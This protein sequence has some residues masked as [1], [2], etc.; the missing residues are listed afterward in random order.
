LKRNDFGYDPAGNLY[1]ALNIRSGT[2]IAR[3]ALAQGTISCLPGT[4]TQFVEQDS[5]AVGPTGDL[6]V[7]K[8][9][10]IFRYDPASNRLTLLAALP[11][12]Y[13][14]GP[15]TLDKAGTLY[16]LCDGYI[17]RLAVPTR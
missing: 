6:L 1:L 3:V 7:L 12:E 9:G 11:S 10:K 15:L 5:I 2:C 14:G 16:L 4:R 17:Q 8:Q 13:H